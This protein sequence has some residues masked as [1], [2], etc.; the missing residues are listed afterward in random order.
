MANA[1]SG[2]ADG[3][4]QSRP[5]LF[6]TQTWDTSPFVFLKVRVKPAAD[7]GMRYFINIQTD[8]PGQPA[9]LHRQS[10]VA[11]ITLLPCSAI[12]PVPAP[13]MVRRA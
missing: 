10:S 11:E 3:L 7:E 5:T 6:G 8:G 4:V 9:G 1:L 12:R 2:L 13:L